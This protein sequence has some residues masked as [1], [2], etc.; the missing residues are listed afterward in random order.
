MPLGS[1]MEQ[2]TFEGIWEDIL[3]HAPELTGQ[4]VKLTVLSS[5]KP[6]PQK[7][8]TLDQMLKGRVGR[9]RFQP[10]NLSARTK[11]AFVEL[12][13]DKYKLSGSGQ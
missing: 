1:P 13:A 10:A 5:E 4:R 3:L 2:R 7:P 9:V 11:E 8:L 6:K 12:L